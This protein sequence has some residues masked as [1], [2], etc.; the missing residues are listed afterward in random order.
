MRSVIMG[1]G[2][3]HYDIKDLVPGIHVS[4]PRQSSSS[5]S[6]YAENP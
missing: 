2:E 6:D 1:S 3:Y 5:F 4:Q